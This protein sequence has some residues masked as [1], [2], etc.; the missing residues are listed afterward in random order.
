MRKNNHLIN[1][2]LLI[3]ILGVLAITA[4]QY[5]ACQDDFPDE[6][7]DLAAACQNPTLPVFAPHLNTHP[8]PISLL[9]IL[10]FQRTN[11]HTTS[12]RC[13]P[14]SIFLIDFLLEDSDYSVMSYVRLV[15][16]GGGK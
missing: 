4:Q 5:V 13:Y 14:L 6:F 11:L 2:L 3:S 1:L 7:L 16:A 10:C 15:F 9:K 12:L 8:I